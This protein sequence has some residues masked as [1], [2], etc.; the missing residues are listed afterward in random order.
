[1]GFL[2]WLRSFFSG[3]LANF[4]KPAA[5]AI[6]VGGGA[7]LIAVATE[8]VQMVARDPAL[9]T[10]EAK[11]SAAFSLILKSLR[12]KGITA[13]VSVVNMVIEIAVQNLKAAQK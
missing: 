13:G 9:V 12:D 11:R 5:N 3:L 1:M 10:D 2:A 8:A 7:V 6:M 4:L